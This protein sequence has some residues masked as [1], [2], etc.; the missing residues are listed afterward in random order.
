M[1]EVIAPVP[2]KQKAGLKNGDRIVVH[3]QPPRS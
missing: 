1:L 3:V 2:I